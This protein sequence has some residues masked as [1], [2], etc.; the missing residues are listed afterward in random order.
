MTKTALI[1][2]NDPTNLETFELMAQMRGYEVK[3][4]TNQE[5][6]ERSLK[7]GGHFDRVLQDANLGKNGAIWTEPA[8]RSYS[9]LRKD[10]EQGRAKF[11]ALS[12]TGDNIIT[13]NQKGIPATEKKEFLVEYTNFFD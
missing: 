13:L 3:R 8:E 2:M 1:A 10:I 7:E 4:A 12:S 6:I 11:L 5:E 9:I